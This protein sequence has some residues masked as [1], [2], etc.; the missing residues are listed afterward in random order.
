MKI[1]SKSLTKIE[2]RKKTVI[3]DQFLNVVI[4]I[5]ISLSGEYG[6]I[7]ESN[8]SEEEFK[9]K[10]VLELSLI[11]YF[12]ENPSNITLNIRKEINILPQFNPEKYVNSIRYYPLKPSNII[13]LNIERN[14]Y[15]ANMGDMVKSIQ[16]N[17]PSI[18]F[19]DFKEVKIS[20]INRSFDIEVKSLTDA[21]NFISTISPLF[22][23]L[24]LINYREMDKKTTAKTSEVLIHG[25]SGEAML[26]EEVED[27][28]KNI[29]SIAPSKMVM[30][31]P[32]LI[33]AKR[34]KDEKFEYLEFLKRVF[35]ELYR[36]YVGGLPNPMEIQ[37]GFEEVKL[38]VKAGKHIYVIDVDKVFEDKS[39]NYY[40][41]Y[42]RDRLKELYSQGFGY[43]VFYGKGVDRIKNLVQNLFIPSIKTL[44]KQFSNTLFPT[45]I[46][47]REDLN[48]YRLA[49]LMWGKVIKFKDIIDSINFDFYAV[50]L[51]NK[52]YDKIITLASD[53]Y[54]IIRVN[55]S[56]R[57]EEKTGGESLLHYG[58]KAFTVKYLIE[59]EKIPEHNIFTE[60]RINDIILD[61]FVK[62][63]PKYGDLAI[64]IETLYGTGLPLLKLRKTIESR[65]SKGLK[66]WIIIPNPQLILFLKD[67]AKL[68]NIYRKKY[69]EHIKIF[70]LDIY[71]LKLI[72]LQEIIKKINTI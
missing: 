60:H 18:E 32:F 39:I 11:E 50:T 49:N 29:F 26:V 69:P 47:I 52:F 65:I 9:E 19:K 48:I 15:F 61:I 53:P 25:G 63:H 7:M 20:D 14:I 46:N 22:L 64:E 16:E 37:A 17:I 31:R 59:T 4:R 1:T 8:I 43:L 42:V 54:M 33:L 6:K 70:T 21:W 44:P 36:I 5:P 45:Q 57:D 40:E 62:Q 23:K 67:I 71:S 2:Y 38:D 12:R 34:P 66:L 72:S 41:T 55:P 68:G 10:K 35:R 56:E 27:V 3:R 58:I 28:F 24:I 13:L 30:D 51:E